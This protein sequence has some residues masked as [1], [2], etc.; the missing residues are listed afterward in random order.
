MTVDACSLCG[1]RKK[2][3]DD[4]LRDMIAADIRT[5]NH[6]IAQQKFH[7]KVKRAVERNQSEVARRIVFSSSDVELHT[8]AG[9]YVGQGF[10]TPVGDLIDE[11]IKYIARGL[12]RFHYPSET[13]PD[14]TLI[15]ISQLQDHQIPEICDVLQQTGAFHGPFAIG[16]PSADYPPVAEWAGALGSRCSWMWIVRFYGGLSFMAYGQCAESMLE[17]SSQDAPIGT[18]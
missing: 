13:V 9:I 1:N 5:W 4:A 10:S 3:F 8:L 11:E 16:D 17:A 7:G 12:M 18:P 15:R 2:R 14:D 6:P